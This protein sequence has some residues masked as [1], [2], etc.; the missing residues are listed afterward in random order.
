[1][2]QSY[3]YD[4][5]V[6]GGG[7]GG[8]RCSRVAAQLGATVG[9]VEERY[10]GGTCVNVGCV[11]KKLLVYGS[12]IRAD[13]EDAAGF[14]WSV[15][16][17]SFAWKTLIANKDKQIARLN[18]VYE[19][20]LDGAG[21]TRYSGRGVLLD[22]HTIAIGERRVTAETILLATGGWPKVPQIPG[23]ELALTSNE[24]FAL[25]EL[26]RRVVIVGGG[27]IAVEFAS[28]LNGCGVETTLLYRGSLFLRGFDD[29]VRT[30][31][32]EQMK[33]RGVD[34]RFESN[35]AA[36]ERRGA[37]IAVQLED[38]S[39]IETDAVLF[40]TGRAPLTEG[41]G[42]EAAGVETD[43]R[44]AIVVDEEFRTNVP[45]IYAVGDVIGRV[46]L[47]PVA[48]AEGMYLA[49]RLFGGGAQRPS[50]DVIPT[51]VFSQ[52]SIG[53]V[54]LTEQQARERYGEIVI[55]RSSFTP[56]KNNLSGRDE[57][58][59][60]KLVVDRA[61]DR[62]V[63]CHMVG[64]D[65]GEI[66]QGLAIAMTCGATKAQF[67]QTIGIHPTAAEEF[68]TMRTPVPSG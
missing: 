10:L 3:D 11:P 52:P 64:P 54:G 13:L 6:I 12:Q 7:S 53:T 40:A 55:Y 57:K 42:L 65:A 20:L 43:G 56:L 2:S 32:A 37:G 33:K 26:P 51:A 21:V 60:M 27:Y 31:L 45:N 68:V 30:H 16:E 35:P 9:L 1:M 38:R 5:F 17:P 29:D 8:V 36:L 39:Q 41:L 22:R 59:L 48:L 66:V 34:L 24:V 15:G 4:L 19:G 28:I 47:T 63:G 14:G 62:V 58:M 50:Y 61:S 44:G 18:R 25:D 23:R 67:D 46:Q 49:R